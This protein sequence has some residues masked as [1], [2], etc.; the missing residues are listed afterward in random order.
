MPK[1]EQRVTNQEMVDRLFQA[2][3][4]LNPIELGKVFPAYND[5]TPH[6][7]GYSLWSTLETLPGI[8]SRY[9]QQ[10]KIIL[11]ISGVAAGGK[12]AIRE[13]IEELMPDFTYKAV[14]ATSR[15]PRE[16]EVH[17]LDYYFYKS[18]EEFMDAVERGELIEWVAQGKRLYG[19]PKQSLID[20]LSRPEPVVTSHVEMESGWPGIDRLV[21][22]GSLDKNVF[23][24]KVFVLPNM[25][26]GQY[27]KEWLPGR[28]D[29]VES[30]LLRAAWE[31]SVAANNADIIVTNT[32]SKNLTA[33]EWESQALVKQCIRLL[34]SEYSFGYPKFDVPFPISPGIGGDQLVVDYHAEMI[35]TAGLTT[36]PH[37][38]PKN[39]L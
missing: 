29:D 20:A 25:T 7:K 24:L 30:R 27:A 4:I 15:K 5:F 32:M 13:T 2:N 11:L 26:F 12:D 28:R 10:D 31:I 36:N 3:P 6:R 34:K 1:A 18:P 14:T 8:T 37:F 38:K 35:K 17:G 39:S 33:L 23:A 9:F 19:M 16:G 21:K 22:S